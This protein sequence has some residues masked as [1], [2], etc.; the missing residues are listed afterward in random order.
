MSPA[1]KDFIAKL[2]EADPVNRTN[3]REL[4]NHLWFSGDGAAETVSQGRAPSPA[5]FRVAPRI[6]LDAEADESNA[7]ARRVSVGIHRRV[8]GSGADSESF[9]SSPGASMKTRVGEWLAFE[10][11]VCGHTFEGGVRVCSLERPVCGYVLVRPCG[12]TCLPFT[13]ASR[14]GTSVVVRPYWRPHCYAPVPL[15]PCE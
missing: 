3:A 1:C 4:M 13:H 7:P 10:G 11:S 9:S 5:A 8:S 14:C 2:L 6:P 12:A 15:Q